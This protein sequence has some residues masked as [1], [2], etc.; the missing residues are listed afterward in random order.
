MGAVAM[1]AVHAVR[2]GTLLDFRLEDS[3]AVLAICDESSIDNLRSVRPTA[4]SWAGCWGSVPPQPG[5]ISDYA[6][7]LAGAPRPVCGGGHARRRA[8]DPDL[9]QRHHRATPKGALIPHR[10][11]IG[12]LSGF[13]CSQ[14]WFGF[15]GRTD[16]DGPTGVLE[17]GRLGLDRWP[18]GRAAAHARTSAA[19]SWPYRA[20]FAPAGAPSS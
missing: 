2:P 10:A 6:Q 15:D 20:G 14:N 18:D 4:R 8:A 5:L 1:P 13:V 9:H 17:P 19:R 11:L 16:A 3:E 7:A 12:N